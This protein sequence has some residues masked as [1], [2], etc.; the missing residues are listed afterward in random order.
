[1]KLLKYQKYL[2]LTFAITVVV[3]GFFSIQQYFSSS[4]QASNIFYSIVFT[5]LVSINIILVNFPLFEKIKEKYPLNKK[6][7]ISITFGFVIT[8][9]AASLIIIFWVMVFYFTVDQS[10][11][12]EEIDRYG[13]NYVI[14]NNVVTAIL[15]NLFVGGFTI[16]RYSTQE[17]KRAIVEAEKYKRQS[18]ESQYATLVNQ[19]NP[20]FLFNSLN[21]LVSLIPQS[22][23]KAIEFVNRFSRIYRYVLDA[24]DKVVCD[25]KDELEFMDSFCYL[26]KIRFGESLII[27]KRI[28]PDI[29]NGFLPP[30]SL[31]LL[32]ENAIKHNEISK[33]NPLNV[34]I[35]TNQNYIQVENTL[36]PKDVNSVSTGI[37]LK[38]LKE[39]FE[40]VC[41]K[42]PEF[43]MAGN[44]YIARLPIIFEEQ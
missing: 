23:D 43:Y 22:P 16:I 15:V 37:G 44:L 2:L 4:F 8:S 1:M 27:E 14:F 35:Y 5:I 24:K 9:I 33:S 32:I 10:F 39:R 11:V 13:L 6:L 20:H 41:D 26:Q 28:D 18:I 31:Q 19:I 40:H 42:K 3:I 38:N 21:A 7:L 17:W 30:L 34:S 36:R 12:I 25:I 29:L